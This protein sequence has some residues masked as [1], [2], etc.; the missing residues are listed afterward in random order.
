VRLTIRSSG[1]R[2]ST[3]CPIS[4]VPL[5]EHRSAERGLP[6]RPRH[7]RRPRPPSSKPDAAGA[8]SGHVLRGRYEAAR[9]ELGATVALAAASLTARPMGRFRDPADV[10][11]LFANQVKEYLDTPS[12]YDIELILA[13]PPTPS[14]YCGRRRAHLRQ[15][16]DQAPE[17]CGGAFLRQ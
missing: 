9:S 7:S 13:L 5:R 17:Y 10:I 3:D 6:D 15:C 1:R 12:S 14:S 11:A 2:S 4:S 8:P 16:P